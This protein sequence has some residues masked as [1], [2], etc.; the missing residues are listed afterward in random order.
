MGGA[1]GPP[2]SFTSTAA[3]SSRREERAPRLLTAL[4]GVLLLTGCTAGG[5]NEPA[6]G[7]I[8]ADQELATSPRW[9]ERLMALAS[10]I[11]QSKNSEFPSA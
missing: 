4:I 2:R 6:S 11:T 1:A 5:Q 8:P 9:L 10:E 3:W 7:S